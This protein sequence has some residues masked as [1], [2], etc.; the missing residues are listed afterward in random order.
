MGA[1]LVNFLVP[2]T[3][4]TSQKP[5]KGG[6]LMLTYSLRRDTVYRWE[7]VTVAET[8]LVKTERWMLVLISL[9][10][11]SFCVGIPWDDPVH[12]QTGFPFSVKPLWRHPQRHS[13]VGPLVVPNPVK[14]MMGMGPPKI[15]IKLKQWWQIPWPYFPPQCMPSCPTLLS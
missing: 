7:E 13:L 14:L 1:V 9:P 2:V 10:P 15:L 4:N 12:I 5:L 11:V 6:M 8:W 3:K